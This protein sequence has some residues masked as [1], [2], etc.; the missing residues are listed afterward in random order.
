MRALV[1]GGT[2]MLGRAVTA[3]ARD[4]GWSALAPSH[5]QGDV[6]DLP[7]VHAL[8]RAFRPDLLVNCAAY[9][10][11]DDC[12]TRRDVANAVN[13]TAVG[14]LA[15]LADELGARLVHVSSDYVFDGRAATPYREASP[16]APLSAYGASKLLGEQEALR[17]AHA[18]V[19]RASWLF[20]P[21]GPNF[22]ATMLQLFERQRTQGTPVRV[23]ADQV[24]APTYTPFLA[25]A[26]CDLAARRATGLVHY[27]NRD[28]V[29]WH[30]FATAIADQAGYSLEIAAIATRE[31]PR[32]AP[33]PSYSVLDVGKFE[34]LVGRRVEPWSAGIA[35]Y[36]DLIRRRT[37]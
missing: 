25:R 35:Q 27:R 37:G 6:T 9:T 2:G 14:G 7:R 18:L 20:G 26:L 29:S 4:R 36:L 23:V 28:A 19:V 1:L 22:A 8:A 32:P 21:G 24:G 31:F 11:V 30:G 5:G 15:R 16:T 34:A 10:K 3:E 12:E 33:R 17:S 13:G